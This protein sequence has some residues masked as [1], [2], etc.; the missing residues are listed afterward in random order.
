ML[1]PYLGTNCSC[2][3]YLE[4]SWCIKEN[5]KS[6]LV[7]EMSTIWGKYCMKF[8][9]IKTSKYTTGSFRMW[10]SW[11]NCDHIYI[12]YI[13]SLFVHTFLT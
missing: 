10:R 8:Q 2:H 12:Y 9:D 4:K 1:L 3:Y 11:D 6:P 5:G 13:I 7:V